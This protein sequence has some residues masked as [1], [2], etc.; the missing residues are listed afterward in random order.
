MP[1]PPHF[2]LS[3]DTIP[4]T[5]SFLF[6]LSAM[7]SAMVVLGRLFSPPLWPSS[8]LFFFLPSAS[9]HVFVFSGLLHKRCRDTWTIP[10]TSTLKL[11]CSLAVDIRNHDSPI[12]LLVLLEPRTENKKG[13]NCLSALA[14]QLVLIGGVS[15]PPQFGDM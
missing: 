11:H 2:I 4:R 6:P 10:H 12:M 13:G 8:T 7:L 1:P 5:L 3:S 9:F 14:N 15:K